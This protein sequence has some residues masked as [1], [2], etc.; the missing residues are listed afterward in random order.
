M[1]L[2]VPTH[3][4]SDLYDALVHTQDKVLKYN[5]TSKQQSGYISFGLD[6]VLAREKKIDFIIRQ[7]FVIRQ[8]N[9]P[10]DFLTQ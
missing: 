6:H 7:T 1:S 8:T 10:P 4:Q 5:T 9:A 3:Q 2:Y